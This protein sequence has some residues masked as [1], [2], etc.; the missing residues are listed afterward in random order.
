MCGLYLIS[1][2]DQFVEIEFESFQVNSCS[3]GGLVSVID[4]WELNGQ[5]FPGAADH[6][7]PKSL[8]YHEFCNSK[9][10]GSFVMSQNVGLVEFR[11]PIQGEA[12]KLRVKFRPNPKRKFFPFN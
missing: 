5:F 10:V 8:R 11:L 7:L 9:P 1:E 4:G 3:A 2:P 12:F 6:Q